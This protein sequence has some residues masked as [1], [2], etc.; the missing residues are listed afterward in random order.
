MNTNTNDIIIRFATLLVITLSILLLSNCRRD[1]ITTDT[2]ARLAFST[3]TLTFDTVFTNIGST[4]RGFLVYNNN[5]QGVNISNIRLAGGEN[6]NFRLNI[7]GIA[8]FTRNDVEVWA[9]DSIYVFVEVTIDPLGDN[10]P[11]I[12]EDS[13]IFETNGNTQVV[14]LTA[15]G[16]EANFF[17]ENTPNG[18]IIGITGDTTWT[19]DKPYVIFNSVL[20]NENSKLT[21]EAGTRIHLFNNSWFFVGGTLEVLGGTDTTDRVCFTGVRLEEFYQDIPGQWNGIYILPQSTNNHI[22]GATIK[23][24]VVGVYIDSIPVNGSPNLVI[25]QS[26]IQNMFDTG[27]AG[28]SASVIAANCLLY[29]C[30]QYNFA[31]LLGGFYEFHQCTFANFSNL[32]IDHENPIIALSNALQGIGPFSYTYARFKNCIIFGGEDDE[33]LFADITNTQNDADNFCLRTDP[34]YEVRFQNCLV[35]TLCNA[36]DPIF[37]NCVFNPAFQDTVFRQRFESNY[38]LSSVSPAINLGATYGDTTALPVNNGINAL[39]EV[40]IEGTPRDVTQPD[41]GCFEYAE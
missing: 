16:Q 3:D 23:N 10:I 29:N 1:S 11:Y 14:H 27:I 33:I 34:G 13:V 2:S 17:G 36:D 15:F 40:D 41:A 5:N 32:Y 4:T 9:E 19:N 39:L 6:S 38:R 35:K 7:D 21:I 26:I 25:Q 22:Q 8:S 12:V 20:V 31:S 30:G 24:G 18:Q 37:D 28:Q